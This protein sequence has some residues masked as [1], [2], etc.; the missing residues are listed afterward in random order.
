MT[1]RD[2]FDQDELPGMM[3]AY[4]LNPDELRPR[5]KQLIVLWIA[6]AVLT[7]ANLPLMLSIPLNANPV[8]YDVQARTALDGGVLYRD[9]VEP[10]LPGIVWVHM[11]VRS[12][13][14]WSGIALKAFDLAV[15]GGIIAILLRLA[16]L[17]SD[18][19]QTRLRTAWGLLFLLWFYFSTP[20]SVHCER[21]I[22]QMLPALGAMSLR[23]R[24]HRD[25]ATEQNSN[26]VALLAFLEGVLWG[27]AFWL[28]PFVA[29]PATLMLVAS[30]FLR[31][32]GRVSLIDLTGMVCG[33]LTIG[34]VGIAWL[35][36]TG[37]W[38]YLWDLTL[39]WNP[40]YFDSGREGWTIQRYY[41]IYHVFTPWGLVHL[42]ALPVAGKAL[43][44]LFH[45]QAPSTQTKYR[46]LLSAAYLGWL[47]Q[48]HFLQRLFHYV[49]VPIIF[50]GIAITLSITIEAIE[51]RRFVRMM[52]MAFIT[53]TLV[54][55]PATRPRR[56]CWWGECVRH[57]STAATRD[58]LQLMPLPDWRQLQPVIEFLEQ[59]DLR[60]GDLTAYNVF[61]VNLYDELDVM[62]STRYIL[63]D[64]HI[65]VF[66]RHADE[67]RTTLRNARHRY[68]VSSL[69][70]DHIPP[71]LVDEF[72][73][74]QPPEL[75][76]G[77]PAKLRDE[78]PYNQ[79]L[80]LRSGQ[81]VVHEVVAAN[82]STRS[83]SLSAQVADQRR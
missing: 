37:A 26:Q 21:D 11:F 47:F 80:V 73:P 28:K 63:P 76:V 27:A 64:I 66:T 78:F 71:E 2:P 4:S 81:Y 50:L 3:T 8:L 12:L 13:F 53:V 48:A 45:C 49:H 56:L 15:V 5:S 31:K 59:Q 32:N 58:A 17:S 29:I 10:N 77:F 23:F 35:R 43:W 75:P 38:P 41:S 42:I 46:A 14:G 65:K 22:W 61:I 20:E 74:D 9:V 36:N 83:H 39:N 25:A 33:G 34:I 60:D 82:H 68:V 24:Q 1:D 51:H 62:P 7:V 55:S 18:R 52:T 70:E 6:I 54:V 16:V 72:S 30:H 79:K 67:I 40:D 57:G 69:I 19:S 44:N